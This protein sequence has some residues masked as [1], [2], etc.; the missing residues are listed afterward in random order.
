MA[1]ITNMYVYYQDSSLFVKY[2]TWSPGIG[3]VFV[4]RCLLSTVR[5]VRLVFKSLSDNEEIKFGKQNC[6]FPKYLLCDV[7]Y[8]CHI[9]DIPVL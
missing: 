8:S 4:T 2:N 3:V 7:L 5:Q 6:A 9:T 1:I